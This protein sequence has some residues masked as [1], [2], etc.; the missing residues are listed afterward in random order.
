MPR[1]PNSPGYVWE[2]M[3]GAVWSMCGSGSLADRLSNA[4]LG[5]HT[6]EDHDLAEGELRQQ[7]TYVLDWT[8]RNM[9]G[10]RGV[11][12]LPDDL[13]LRSLIEKMLSVLLETHRK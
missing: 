3:Y 10:D 5:L 12:K 13:E 4:G 7:L 8:K 6:L 2:K 11:K 1:F 9:A